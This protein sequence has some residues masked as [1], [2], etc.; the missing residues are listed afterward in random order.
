MRC[1]IATFCAF[2]AG[3]A[4]S[5]SVPSAVGFITLKPTNTGVPGE[6]VRL[7]RF[8]PDGRLWVAA[9]WPFFLEGGIGII[10]LQTAL[11]GEFG[12]YGTGIWTNYADFVEPTLIQSEYINDIEFEP[13]GIAWIASDGGLVRFDEA[14]G[15][16]QSWNA[17]NAPLI[18]NGIDNIEIHPD[19]HVWFTNDNVQSSNGALFELDPATGTF[20]SYEVGDELPWEAPWKSLEGLEIDSQGHVWVSN[21]VLGD[22]AEFDGTTWT[23]HE[24]GF[25]SIGAIKEDTEGNMWFLAGINGG[26]QFFKFD[27]ETVTQFSAANT[28]MVNTTITALAVDQDGTVYIGNWS[29]QVIA[30]ED[31][32]E[33]W[34][35]FTQQ[36]GHIF[37]INPDPNSDDVFINTPGAVRHVDGNG[38]WLKA[39]NT[40]NTGIPD[41]FIGDMMTDSTGRM[42]FCSA[43]A[44]LSRWDGERWR[45]WGK[46]N[47]EAEA[48]PFGGSEPI[49]SVFE[50]SQ[51]NIWSGGNGIM[52]WSPTLNEVTGFWDWANSSLGVDSF[53]DIVEDAAGD[54]WIASDYTGVYRL[55]PETNDWEQK[56]FGQPFSTANYVSDMELDLEGNLWVATLTS[57]HF[58]NG[59]TWFAVGVQHG[60]PVVGPVKVAAHPTDGS[61]WIGAQNGLIK[62][63]NAEWTVYNSSNS[64]MPADW[65][66]DLQIR[67][68]GLIGLSCH[69]FGPV[70][71]FPSGVV[72]F[73]GVSEWGVY[74]YDTDPLPHYQLGPI[75]FDA[76]GDLWVSTISEGATE[77]LFTLPDANPPMDFDGNKL[78]DS[79]DLNM[80]L[81]GFGC[82]STPCPGDVDKDGDTDSADLNAL[83][84]QFGATFN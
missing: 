20:T 84:A 21:E 29:G 38:T 37:G 77:I 26:N 40:Y 25:G 47:A 4:A 75:M 1:V 39:F 78:V 31:G 11:E 14:A 33:S 70:T 56:L 59:Q 53:V 12:N 52:R 61:L 46:H 76:E 32:G 7:T 16:W 54:I 6:E 2:L 73:D 51:G 27:G 34:F 83:L 43:E 15:T 9:R 8:A 23:L 22:V 72:V 60:S 50:D 74:G 35:T 48:W 18:F 64:P 62:Y 36:N 45:N 5:G 65:V 63:Q 82:T 44:G 24:T 81:S 13:S 71:P 49:D 42:W 79:A 30:T 19:G 58:Y 41:Y 57:L 68:D 10:D 69:E 17:S 28:P 55:N 66:Q 3:S 80:L 67:D